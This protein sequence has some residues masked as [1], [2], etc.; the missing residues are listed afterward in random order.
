M[1]FQVMLLP[2]SYILSL[3]WTVNAAQWLEPRTAGEEHSHTLQQLSNLPNPYHIPDSPYSIDFQNPGPFFDSGL[4][5]QRFLD[6]ALGVVIN[7]IQHR[8]DGPLP[9]HDGDLRA[10]RINGEPYTFFVFAEFGTLTYN[11]TT[12]ILEA[13]SLKSRME[14][15]RERESIILETV[16]GSSEGFAELATWGDGDSLRNKTLQIHPIRNPYVLS[17]SDLS[18]DFEQPVS[19]LVP[20]DVVNCIVSARQRITRHIREHGEGRITIPSIWFT[21]KSVEFRVIAEDV[22]RHVTWND[23]L[24]ILNA[25][26]IKSGREGFQSR[27]GSIIMTNGEQIVAQAV[28]GHA[29]PI[30]GEARNRT[31]ALDS[32]RRARRRISM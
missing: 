24:N 16:T 11:D 7:H 15:Y 10:L 23:T 22:P 31:T 28:L 6:Y 2:S 21:W 12:Q 1:Y 26:A 27:W 9:R 25:F 18:V 14:G 8:G 3:L 29:Y 5:V 13:F 32:H 20:I 19:D 30:T 4:A 17:G